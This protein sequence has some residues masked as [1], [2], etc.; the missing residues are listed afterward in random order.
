[1]IHIDLFGGIGGFALAARWS[2]VETVVTCDISEYANRVM[3]YHFP[4]AYHHNDIR[5]LNKQLLDAKLNKYGP[6]WGNKTILT[7]GFPCQ[8]FSVAG[9]KRGTSDDRYL[10]PEMLR[11]ITDVRPRW[12][13]AENVAGLLS[14]AQP[15][16]VSEMGA[17]G[18]LFAEDS[19]T[20]EE[21]EC[22]ADRICRDLEGISYKVVPLLIPACAVGAPHRRDRVWFVAY[23]HRVGGGE[24]L[25]TSPAARARE[26]DELFASSFAVPNWQGF[27]HFS[28]L[29]G[30]N[31][32]VP[33]ELAAIPFSGWRKRSVTAIGNAIVP[34]IAHAIIQAIQYVEQKI[35]QK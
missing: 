10:W 9:S 33:P 21:Y 19:Y 23:S 6:D 31:D 20:Q 34:Q 15:V 26:R 28:P 32:G 18:D 25:D 3:S 17:G 29:C 30:G 27:P 24:L 8:P 14:M 11:V 22:L 5:T 1:M 16:R 13:I 35:T 4:R 2:G 12:V 7:G